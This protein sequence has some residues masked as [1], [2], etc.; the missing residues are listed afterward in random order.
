MTTVNDLLKAILDT[1]EIAEQWRGLAW[2][3]SEAVLQW[4]QMTEDERAMCLTKVAELTPE[5][6]QLPW[7][8]ATPPGQVPQW[9]LDLLDKPKEGNNA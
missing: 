9:A 7:E 8:A 1:R 4:D 6:L 3:F 5:V 2:V